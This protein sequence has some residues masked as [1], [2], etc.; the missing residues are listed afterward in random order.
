MYNK[1][2]NNL[3]HPLVGSEVSSPC[4][5]LSAH[6]CRKCGSSDLTA[7]AIAARRRLCRKCAALI[8]REKRRNN[9]ER[10]RERD[11][12]EEQRRM[13]DPDRRV[14]VLAR[15]KAREAVR[16]GKMERLPCEVCGAI[17]VDAHHDDYSKPLDVRWLCRVH[18]N[19]HHAKARGGA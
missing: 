7:S 14:K 5:S 17:K 2:M 3:S 10:Y 8:E 12:A 18:H 11:L 6:E 16:R 4:A 9:P 1:G 13:A 15:V 19:E